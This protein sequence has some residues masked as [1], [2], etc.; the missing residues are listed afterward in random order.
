M[1]H[2]LYH[3]EAIILT[4]RPSGEA[5]SFIYCLTRE[6]GLVMAKAE[7]IRH[8]KSKL[9]FSLQNYCLSEV[10]LVRG[11]EIWRITGARLENNYQQVFRQQEQKIALIAKIFS[12]LLRL[13][14]GEEKNEQLFVLVK[15][16]LVFL[17]KDLDLEQLKDLEVLAV[18][19][20]LHSLGYWKKESALEG[21]AEG[22]TWD[23]VELVFV[24]L[25]RNL[26]LGT[27]NDTLKETHL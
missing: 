15:D 5:G 27:I 12:L 16:L 7:G 13:L 6:L 8:L 18:M 14:K 21:L 22:Q 1:S 10:S 2:H 20:I 9:R 19:R 3:T 25:Q 11:K 23:I 17:E 26:A 24:N 4:Q